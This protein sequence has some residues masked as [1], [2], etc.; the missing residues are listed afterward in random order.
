MVS[1][2]LQRP[3]PVQR[4]DRAI[5]SSRKRV[6]VAIGLAGV[7]EEHVVGIGDER[8]ALLRPPEYALADEDD[9]VGW[10]G[11]LGSQGFDV[12][13]AAE[14]QD[15]HPERFQEDLSGL[16]PGSF[17]HCGKAH[18]QTSIQVGLTRAVPA[19]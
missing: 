8:L 17:G 15:G 18:E 4:E 10:V 1:H 14:V 9:A 12:G 2:Q 16:E 3:G 7:E 11:L 5:V 19:A 6:R 13:S